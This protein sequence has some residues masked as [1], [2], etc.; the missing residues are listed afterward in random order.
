MDSEPR[1]GPSKSELLGYLILAL[2]IKPKFGQNVSKKWGRSGLENR[3]FFPCRTA[4][5]VHLYYFAELR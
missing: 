5:F 3:F 1:D 4:W 2:F